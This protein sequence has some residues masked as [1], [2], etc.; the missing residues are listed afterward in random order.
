MDYETARYSRINPPVLHHE[1]DTA[2]SH[3]PPF[4]DRRTF[5]GCVMAALPDGSHAVGQR[6]AIPKARVVRTGA[7]A[8]AI[9]MR[10]YWHAA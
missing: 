10:E 4:A 3:M 1:L 6:L 5:A 8:T 9:R 2:D 7:L